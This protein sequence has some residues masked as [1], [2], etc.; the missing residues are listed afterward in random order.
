MAL[1]REKQRLADE[2]YDIIMQYFYHTHQIPT[3]RELAQIYEVSLHTI[4][5]RIWWLQLDGRIYVG[6]TIPTVFDSPKW[7]K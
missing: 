1:S 2:L 7:R 4:K 3:Q 6:T 5:R